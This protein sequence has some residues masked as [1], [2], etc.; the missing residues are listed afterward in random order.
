MS[1]AAIA[2]AACGGGGGGGEAAVPE[3][4]HKAEGAYVGQFGTDLVFQAVVLEDQQLWLVYGVSEPSNFGSQFG[5]RFVPSSFVAG[6]LNMSNGSISASSLQDNFSPMAFSVTGTYD[7]IASAT[8]D[9]LANG[10][11]LA[12]GAPPAAVNYNYARPASATAVAGT[13]PIVSVAEQTT[14]T[15]S[16]TDQGAL[17]G[18]VRDVC[19][20]G[21]TVTPRSS[22]KNVFDVTYT[23]CS[24]ASYVG[25]A[26]QSEFLFSGQMQQQLL[27]TA[28]STATNSTAGVLFVGNR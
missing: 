27:I 21:G 11:P 18:I 7:K 15:F 28:K 9:L 5:V 13:W 22:G 3:V 17:T 4:D 1:F 12:T 6:R 23:D 26:V 24:G 20:V 2:V 8:L 14:G 19:S 10:S 25:V 16:I